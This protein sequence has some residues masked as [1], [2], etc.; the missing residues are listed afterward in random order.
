MQRE[1]HGASIWGGEGR[2]MGAGEVKGEVGRGT[3][4]FEGV[5]IRKQRHGKEKGS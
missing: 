5:K 3:N 4:S 2:I 1:L